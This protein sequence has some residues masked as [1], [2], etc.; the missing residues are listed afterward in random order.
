[1]KTGKNVVY[2]VLALLSFAVL[3]TALTMPIWALTIPTTASP[4]SAPTHRGQE[5]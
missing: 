1:M 4:S 3:V 2:T 5:R